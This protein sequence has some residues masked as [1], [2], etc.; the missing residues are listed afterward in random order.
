MIEDRDLKDIVLVDN[1]AYSFGSQIDNGIPIIPFY[2]NK[3]DQ[4][5][6]FLAD[7]LKK[8]LNVSDVREFNKNTFKMSQYANYEKPMDV[9]YNLYGILATEQTFQL[10]PTNQ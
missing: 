8:L 10:N 2:D 6:R 3:S 7:Y 9:L 1:A 4:E 5:M